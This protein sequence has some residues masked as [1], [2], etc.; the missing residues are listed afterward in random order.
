MSGIPIPY[1]L[2]D[3]C[4]CRFED[5]FVVGNHGTWQVVEHPE[6]VR[7]GDMVEISVSYGPNGA[8]DVH[9]GELAGVGYGQD[10]FIE[11]VWLYDEA[12]DGHCHAFNCEGVFYKPKAVCE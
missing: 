5:D 2:G 12:G 7:M 6:P 3:D 8:E 10:G 4:M 1:R 9:A 11:Q